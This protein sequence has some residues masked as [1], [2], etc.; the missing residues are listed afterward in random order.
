[1]RGNKSLLSAIEEQFRAYNVGKVRLGGAN[2]CHAIILTPFPFSEHNSAAV[3][4]EASQK[5]L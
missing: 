3:K 4:E 5:V 2:Y 1:M